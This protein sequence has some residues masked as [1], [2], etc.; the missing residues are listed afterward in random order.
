M[1][2]PVVQFN[3]STNEH[4]VIVCDTEEYSACTAIDFDDVE[5]AFVIFF[6]LTEAFL[7]QYGYGYEQGLMD[8]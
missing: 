5:D 8:S 3:F 7:N 1:I 6:E 4:Q 2:Y